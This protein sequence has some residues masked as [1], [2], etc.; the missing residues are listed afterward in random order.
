MWVK[1][2]NQYLSIFFF[3]TKAVKFSNMSDTKF[4]VSGR[5]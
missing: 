3:K 1:N 2:A 5:I 4:I